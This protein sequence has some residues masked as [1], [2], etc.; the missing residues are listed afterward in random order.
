MPRLPLSLPGAVPASLAAAGG[1]EGGWLYTLLTKAGVD[2]STAQTVV[3][4]VVRP[5]EVVLVLAVAALVAR[6]GARLLRRVL[7]RATN[8]AAARGGDERGGA[9]VSTVVA[10]IVNLWRLFVTVVALAI[11]LGM[12]GI[13]LTPI[14]ASATVIGATIGFGAQSLV[15]DYLSGMLLTMEDQYGIGDTDHRRT[16]SP[17]WWRT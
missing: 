4:F 6:Y 2:P 10:L 3:D 15:R 5:L 13:D 8:R 7:T 16:T 11:I 17:A 12:L 9:R 1:S 14:L